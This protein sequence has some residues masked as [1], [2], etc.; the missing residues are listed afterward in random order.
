MNELEDEPELPAAHHG[1]VPLRHPGERPVPQVDL[2]LRRLR[3]P[4][5]KV[6]D[7]ALTRPARP[8]DGAELP[9]GNLQREPAQGVDPSLALPEDLAD[10][11]EADHRCLE[12]VGREATGS[13][14]SVRWSSSFSTR[15]TQARSARTR[16]SARR[17]SSRATNLPCPPSPTPAR[18]FV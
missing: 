9:S 7:R 5:D 2:P 17:R 3:Q 6:Q 14:P 11:V 4:R 16:M 8:H 18:R 13:L 10:V 15:S 12:N 1:R